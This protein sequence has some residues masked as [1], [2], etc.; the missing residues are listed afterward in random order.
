M[1][2]E[3]LRTFITFLLEVEMET[4]RLPERLRGALAIVF[5]QSRMLKLSLSYAHVSLIPVL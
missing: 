3:E 1:I 4:L 5:K 2:Q